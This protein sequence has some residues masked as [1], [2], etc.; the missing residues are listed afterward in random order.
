[1]RAGRR[2]LMALLRFWDRAILSLTTRTEID[3][4]LSIT[5]SEFVLFVKNIRKQVVT[6]N[7]EAFKEGLHCSN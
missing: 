6:L 1:M 7:K 5:M 4:W 3:P 2:A